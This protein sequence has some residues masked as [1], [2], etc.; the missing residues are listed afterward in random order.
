MSAQERTRAGE[1]KSDRENERDERDR[2]ERGEES[3]KVR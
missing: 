3:N 1:S 2:E